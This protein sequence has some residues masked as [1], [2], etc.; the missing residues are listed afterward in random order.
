MK[1][2]TVLRFLLVPFNYNCTRCGFVSANLVNMA[3]AKA[4][5]LEADLKAE[6]ERLEVFQKGK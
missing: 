6:V 2:Q 5:K 4:L 1:T 3:A